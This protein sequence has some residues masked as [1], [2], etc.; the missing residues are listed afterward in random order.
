MVKKY[1][2]P[3]D[4]IVWRGKFPS[5]D[6]FRVERSTEMY[7]GRL[8]KNGTTED[9]IVVGDALTA[10]IGWLGYEQTA[11]PY[12]PATKDTI[13]AVN[14]RAVVGRGGMFGIRGKIEQGCVVNFGDRLANWTNGKLVGPVIPAN[15]GVYLGIPFV[16]NATPADTG[17]DLPAD[18]IVY[19]DPFVDVA[20]EV[21]GSTIDVGTLATEQGGVADGFLD[22]VSC[23]SAGKVWPVTQAASAGAITL[24]SNLGGAAITSADSSAIVFKLPKGFVCD[25]VAMSIAYTTSN[26]TIAGRFWLHLMAEG[27]G[28]VAKAQENVNA[29]SAATTAF[30]QSLI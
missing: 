7:P 20:T 26:H 3:V 5:Q 19:G 15:G 18:M 25:G 6:E 28:V 21:A 22:G 17:L 29:A 9:D 2:A 27:L 13:Y 24:G 23:A 14:D 1:T 8:V 12:M 16:K 4:A 30:V 10:P 11:I